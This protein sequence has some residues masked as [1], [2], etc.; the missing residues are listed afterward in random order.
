MNLWSEIG[1]VLC[2]FPVAKKL[3]SD[4]GLRCLSVGDA[5]RGMLNNH[6]D[7]ELSLM[8]NW[9]LHKGKT[10]PDELAIQAL[11][12]SLMESVCNTIG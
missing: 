9:H 2:V 5:L 4:Y 1:F 11:D 10:V 3:A 12:I 6:P 7:S 8:L